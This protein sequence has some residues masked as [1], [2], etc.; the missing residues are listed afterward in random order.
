MSAIVFNDQEN[1]IF[2]DNFKKNYKENYIKNINERLD[3]FED[4]IHDKSFKVMLNNVKNLT[5]FALFNEPILYFDVIK[6][7]NKRKIEII[8]VNNDT[9]KYII[10]N[11]DGS[12][13]FEGIILL[14][15]PITKSGNTIAI[16]SD[17]K[18]VILK[19]NKEQIDKLKEK[20]EFNLTLNNNKSISKF[21]RNTFKNIQKEFNDNSDFFLLYKTSFYSS[22]PSLNLYNSKTQIINDYSHHTSKEEY[23][24]I[25]IYQEKENKKEV[26]LLNKSNEKIDKKEKD[27]NENT[28]K[29]KTIQTKDYTPLTKNQIN[30][31]ISLTNRKLMKI[32]EFQVKKKYSKNEKKH[33]ELASEKLL[34]RPKNKNNNKPLKKKT[35]NKESK[36]NSISINSNLCVSQRIG[37][38]IKKSKLKNKYYTNNVSSPSN[39][40]FSKK[41]KTKKKNKKYCRNYNKNNINYINIIPLTMTKKRSKSSKKPYRD[42]PTSF[43]LNDLEHSSFKIV[44]ENLSQN[45][46]VFKD[47]KLKSNNEIDENKEN[48]SN[49]INKCIKKKIIS[50]SINDKLYPQYIKINNVSKSNKLFQISTEENLLKFK[51]K[52]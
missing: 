14:N 11:F 9:Q 33:K 17:L 28:L 4:I 18:K 41:I 21:K 51:T 37:N 40:F 10:V 31:L 19:C 46:I 26:K 48:I 43:I 8:K 32:Y 23:Y 24:L 27:N 45:Q 50:N 36:K 44:Q 42:F 13:K 30:S 34:M 5:L 16:L 6:D 2:L 39:A 1:D 29:K 52:S 25:D 20:E 49:L 47:F 15:P 12:E 35:T 7:I 38:Y 22:F 3:E